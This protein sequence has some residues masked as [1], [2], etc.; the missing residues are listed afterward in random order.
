MVKLHPSAHTE[1]T[2]SQYRELE[3]IADSMHGH[4]EGKGAEWAVRARLQALGLLELRRIP[5]ARVR[6]LVAQPEINMWFITEAGRAALSRGY[7]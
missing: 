4:P 5:E 1:L 7:L 2:S 6:N 3:R